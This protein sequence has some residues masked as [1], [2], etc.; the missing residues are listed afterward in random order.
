M[1]E[2]NS[3]TL[4]GSEYKLLKRIV[5]C[6]DK[7]GDPSFLSSIRFDDSYANGCIDQAFFE[8]YG[9]NL[10]DGTLTPTGIKLKEL[11]QSGLDF[12]HD[13]EQKKLDDAKRT[14][15]Q[16]RH[17]Y[18]VAS[19]GAIAGGILGLFGGAFSAQLLGWVTTLF[20]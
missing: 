17:D 13:Y 5:D 2:M 6:Y 20:Q 14:K 1:H 8:L 11:P 12:V 4:S 10:I 15:Q 19:Y 16:R 3:I 7:N 18:K 9:K